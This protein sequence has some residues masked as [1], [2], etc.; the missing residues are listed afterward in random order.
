M[1]TR[2]LFNL[3]HDSHINLILLSLTV[4]DLINFLILVF[5]NL[6]WIRDFGLICC[7]IE[8]IDTY[9]ITVLDYN[10][11]MCEEYNS[12][13]LSIN[14]F[15]ENVFTFYYN[16]NNYV[17]LLLIIYVYEIIFETFRLFIYPV[18]NYEIYYFKVIRNF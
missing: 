12:F 2:D 18:L 14:V 5:I 4:D 17:L 3:W 8:F 16:R 15:F 10:N 7:S 9:L 1:F 6:Y 11:E 13:Y